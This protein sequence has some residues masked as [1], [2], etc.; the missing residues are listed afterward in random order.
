MKIGIITHYDVHNHGALLQLH[1]LKQMLKTLGQDAKA[2]QFK[3]N[4]DFLEEE[5]ENKYNI[6]LKS[7]PFYLR[8][9]M[10]KGLPITYFNY[11]KKKI[12]DQ[13]KKEKELIGDYYSH[14]KQISAIFIGSD[15]VFSIECGLVPILWGFGSPSNHMFSY[16]ASFGPS[17]M[18]WIQQKNA[19][20]FIKGGINNLS[21]ISVRDENSRQIIEQ[22]SDRKATLVCDPVILYGYQEEIKTFHKPLPYSYLVIYSY[23]NNMN[24]PQEIEKIKEFAQQHHWKIVSVG[25]YHK[26]CDENINVSPIELVN[27]IWGA[28][29][30]ITDTFHGS[31]ISLITNKEFITKIRGNGNKLRFLLEQHGLTHRITEQFENLEEIAKEPINY[32]SVNEI[33]EKEREVSMNY[34]KSCLEEIKDE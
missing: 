18:D 16:A 23:D 32:D 10:K 29:F 2:L 7:I 33:M 8:Y 28:E 6:T 1:S 19:V 21:A 34:L 22:L 17:T 14:A 31:V 25:F 30:V 4:Y 11:R 13:F 24:D 26:W 12:L 27:Y 15:E 5:A 20:E 9:L 3:H